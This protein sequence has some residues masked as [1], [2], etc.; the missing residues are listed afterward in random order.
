MTS[1]ECPCGSRLQFEDCCGPVLARTVQA[2]T[3]EALM[4]SRYT[5]YTLQETEYLLQS[6]H[7]DFRPA[8]LPM[9]ENLKWLGLKIKAC[10]HGLQGDNNGVVEFVARYKIGGRAHRLHE[11]SRFT[12]IDGAWVYIDGKTEP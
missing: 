6:W 2:K 10:Q 5:A 11:I 8:S 3:A 7:K 4:R 9:D 12:K 1:R